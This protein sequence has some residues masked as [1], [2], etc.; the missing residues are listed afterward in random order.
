MK[1]ERWEN[2]KNLLDVA[3][4]LQGT[5]RHKYL[6]EACAGDDDL[7][8]E[9]ESLLVSHEQAGNEFLKIPAFDVHA[10]YTSRVGRR[11]GPYNIIE[12]IGQGGMGEVYRAIRADGQYTK[13]VAIKLVRGGLDSANVLERFRNERQILASLDHPNIARLMDGATED[14]IPYLVMEL[15][16]GVPI[17]S[18]C[19]Q[20]RLNITQRLQLFCDVCA[21]VQYAHQRLV[22]HRDIKPG[23]ILVTA[24]GTPKLLDFGIA[25]ILDP[26]V[27]AETTF[28]HPMT[29]EYASPEQI[30]GE[31]VTTAADVYSLGVVLYQMLTGKSPYP[32]DTRLSHD[33][34]R[35]IC[36]SEPERPSSVIPK[37]EEVRHN[38]QI[39]QLTPAD[40]SSTREGSTAKLR[41]RLRGDLDTIVLKALRKEPQLRYASVEQFAEDIRRHLEGLPVKAH[42][43]SWNYHA[44]K[45][46]RRHRAAM[47][48]TAI[49]AIT[50]IA[51]VVLIVHEA[52]VASANGQRAEKRFNDV[53]KLANSLIFEVHDS[54]RDLPGST[55]ARKLLVSRALEYLDSLAQQSKGDASLQKELA[56]AY[57][58][59]GDV[60]G[61]P[62]S[63]NLGDTAGALRSYR[64]ALAIRESLAAERPSD[65][66]QQGELAENYFRI[67]NVLESIGDFN[68]ALDAIRKA[69]PIAQRMAEG[70]NDPV[71]ADRL[72]GSYYYMAGMLGQTGDPLSALENYQKAA[73]IR[74]TALQTNPTN[75]SLNTHLAAD[76]AGVAQS[77]QRR[78]DLV[79]AIQI[80]G[81]AIDTLEQISRTYPNNTALREY[82]AEAINRSAGFRQD[83][84]DPAGALEAYRH[85]H[86]IFLELLTA[87]PKN[88]LAKT[89]FG[90]SDT[91]I[92][93]SLVD[94]GKPASALKVYREAVASFEA[95][96]PASSSNRYIRSGLAGSYSGLGDAYSA[97][98]AQ[99]HTS[100]SLALERWRD[101]H[102][103]Y[104]K[105]NAVWIDK[106]KRGEL[107]SDERSESR[108]VM[109][110][111][112]K[113]NMALD[114][115]KPAHNR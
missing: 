65:M 52:R 16:E 85:A 86:H 45:F 55:P 18:Y 34:A 98:A 76:Y 91:G 72:A 26:S 35:A 100:T 87:D 48:V 59:V 13:E 69:L 22:I 89:N 62:Y 99:P 17:D 25:K 33:L 105:S 28:A 30:R 108:M 31:T 36:E 63:A 90:F 19:D 114:S 79:H 32:G 109:Q 102:A 11:L 57:E 2:V 4:V 3:L 44:G 56:T 23:N 110:S 66:Q 41:R 43:G 61:Y 53:R 14:D 12:E 5:Q 112:A 84:G 6:L 15:V 54:I 37:T 1:T 111:L 67:A 77:M 68:A 94:L 80:Q 97:L 40:V 50:L 27:R 46:I 24:E 107:E 104:E 101:A 92:A 38:G 70:T 7:R 93:K 60:L 115:A 21:A 51:G 81:N 47:A 74:K 96:S 49:M 78:G 113:C 75:L 10:K 71:L 64:K 20:G 103:W 88:S 9:V 8:L 95:M 58:R 39:A 29:P 42:K 73:S 106:E 82:L 83:Q